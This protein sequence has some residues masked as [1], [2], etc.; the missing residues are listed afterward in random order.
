MRP[1]K[2]LGIKTY[3]FVLL[4]VLTAIPV[5]WLGSQHAA[6]VATNDLQQHDQALASVARSVARQFDQMLETRCRDLEL[7][8]TGIEVLGGPEAPGVRELLVRHW[9]EVGLLH[10]DLPG[11]QRRQC[12]AEG[13]RA[14]SGRDAW[15]GR[16]LR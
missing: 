14:E 11:G 3:L 8:A 6:R 15:S 10:G 12:V 16:Q 1:K 5:L 2:A 13:H 9:D 4:S 7:L